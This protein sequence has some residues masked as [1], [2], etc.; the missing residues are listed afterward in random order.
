M[1]NK[2]S[3]NLKNPILGFKKLL[4]LTIKCHKKVV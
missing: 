1:Q 3:K 2:L 4:H